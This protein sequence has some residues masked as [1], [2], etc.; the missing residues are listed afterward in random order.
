EFSGRYS[1]RPD[2]DRADRPQPHNKTKRKD[3]AGGISFQKPVCARQ[4]RSFH[5]PADETP[6]SRIPA[7]ALYID[8]PL[9][10]VGMTEK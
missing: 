2:D 6:S 8:P 1:R 10:R 5:Q 3:E 4:R 9:G 7:Y